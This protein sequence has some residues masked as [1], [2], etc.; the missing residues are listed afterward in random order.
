MYATTSELR[1]DREALP[2][3]SAPGAGG[4]DQLSL[5]EV[6]DIHVP[7]S[8]AESVVAAASP[9]GGRVLDPFAGYGTTLAACENLER[10]GVGVELLPEHVRIS[11]ARA[12]HSTVIEGDSRGLYR[13]VTGPFDLCF[14][15]PPFLTR[16][17]HPAN[18][19]TGYELDEGTYA[20]YV[21]SLAGIAEQARDVLAPGAFLV[22]NIANIRFRDQTTRLAWDVAAAIDRVLPFI[23]ETTVVWDELPHDFTGDYLLTFGSE[24]AARQVAP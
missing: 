22:L 8:L 20:S 11:Q 1:A 2:G 15:A 13:L 3:V 10:T 19:L 17:D 23:A 18:P 9:P 24:P 5:E 16:N 7:L 6:V 4:P 14:S 21:D 12:P